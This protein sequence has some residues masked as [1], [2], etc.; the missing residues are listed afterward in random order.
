MTGWQWQ[1]QRESLLVH[2]Q[3]RYSADERPDCRSQPPALPL[4]PHAVASTNTSH[5]QCTMYSKYCSMHS[6]ALICSLRGNLPPTLCPNSSALSSAKSACA[7]SI[8]AG[9]VYLSTRVSVKQYCTGSS[10]ADL[11]FV[12]FAADSYR[13]HTECRQLNASESTLHQIL[14]I[15]VF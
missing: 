12:A 8:S 14:D 11:T 4:V 7:I 3:P 1:W 15:Y 5:R 13:A 2:M 6:K 10:G 9:G